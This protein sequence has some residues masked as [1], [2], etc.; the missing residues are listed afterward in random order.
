[1]PGE[2]S[3]LKARAFHYV[4]PRSL[5]EALRAFVDADDAVYI[6]GG[7]SLVPAM[8]L[9]LQAPELLIDI[10]RLPEL[11]GLCADATHLRIGAATR[12]DD[13]LTSPLVRRHAPL[14]AEAAAHVAHPAI[15]NRGTFAGSLALADPAAE[16][17]AMALAL[18]AEIEVASPSGTRRIAAEAFFLDLYE[19]A[20]EPGEIIVAVHVP[21][22]QPGS[23]FAFDELARRRGDYAIVGL[24]VNGLFD[25]DRVQRMRLGF[26]S[27]GPTALRARAAEDV[28]TGRVLDAEAI[29][30]AQA[31]L[32]K[33]LAPTDDEQMPASMRLHL[34]RVLMGRLLGRIAA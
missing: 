31:A 23:R 8:A 13:V 26:L 34:A 22:A 33:D 20:L 9:R 32:E 14:L 30:D 27:M 3:G 19:T 17:P 24:G 7:Q 18:D 16:F 29:R 11:Q 12:H 5:A 15:R 21:L 2:E 1:M 10:V 25:C 4:R 28:L 6:A